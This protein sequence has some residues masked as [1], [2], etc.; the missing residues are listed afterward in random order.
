MKCFIHQNI[1]AVGICTNCGRACCNS[2]VVN[3]PGKIICK[4]C[5]ALKISQ[6][7]SNNDVSGKKV[8]IGKPSGLPLAIVFMILCTVIS[9]GLIIFGLGLITTTFLI[10]G[11]INVASQKSYKWAITGGIISTFIFFPFGVPALILIVKNKYFFKSY[12]NENDII[13]SDKPY[14]KNG[15]THQVN[16]DITPNSVIKTDGAKS[17]T[18]SLILATFLSFWSYLY[19]YKQDRGKFWITIGIIGV[20]LLSSFSIFF[21]A[22]YLEQKEIEREEEEER[23]QAEEDARNGVGRSNV[24]IEHQGASYF[25]IIFLSSIL[26]PIILRIIVIIERS[27]KPPDYFNLYP[28]F[29]KK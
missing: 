19:T 3:I 1:D 23:K 26:I 15:Y 5:A 28:N 20:I 2:C 4:E 14:H 18:I 13:V 8:I 29:K 22:E 12:Q 21:I 16:K 11:L 27:T 24:S 6:I 10:I 7:E 9:I 25:F 17:K